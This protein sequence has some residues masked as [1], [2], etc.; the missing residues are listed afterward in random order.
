MC[1]RA[2]RTVR[3]VVRASADF[4]HLAP[5]APFLTGRSAKKNKIKITK[6]K[7]L[8]KGKNCY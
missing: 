5:R 1:T 3:R 8:K 2:Q 4:A 7:K 6:N